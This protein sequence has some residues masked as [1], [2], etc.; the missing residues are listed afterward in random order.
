MME[1]G[2]A[3]ETSVYLYEI[4]Q[5]HIPEGCHLQ[6]KCLI[7]LSTTTD[8]KDG[9]KQTSSLFTSIFDLLFQHCLHILIKQTDRKIN[10]TAS[11]LRLDPC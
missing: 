6:N 8:K 3:F 9:V 7:S 1:T 2:H 10:L 11:I 4:A 5:R